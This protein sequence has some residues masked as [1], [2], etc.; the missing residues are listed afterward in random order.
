VSVDVIAVAAGL[1]V[2][3]LVWRVI[4]RE[5]RTL[6]ATATDEAWAKGPQLLRDPRSEPPERSKRAPNLEGPDA[7]HESRRADWG[8][9]RSTE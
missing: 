7:R 9:A 6:D 3:S 5:E 1:F 4:A 8:D 2:L